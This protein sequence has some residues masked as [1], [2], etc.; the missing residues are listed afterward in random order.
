MARFEARLGFLRYAP[1]D[2]IARSANNYNVS[3][4]PAERIP[5][6]LLHNPQNARLTLKLIRIYLF[7]NIIM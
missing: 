5:R 2:A 1:P 7:F 4:P 3:K 6:P